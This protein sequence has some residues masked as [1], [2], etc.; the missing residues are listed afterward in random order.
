MRGFAVVGTQVY[1]VDPFAQHL[2]EIDPIDGAVLATLPL[3]VDGVSTSGNGLAMNPDS[4]VVFAVVKNPTSP[5]GGRL[6][7]ILDV[8]TG[9][10]TSIGNTGLKLAGITFGEP[11]TPAPPTMAPALGPLG[12]ATLALALVSA[13]LTGR[14]RVALGRGPAPRDDELRETS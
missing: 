6:L 4:G 5:S 3:T 2:F 11:N 7:A 13:A 14:R 10:A 9:Q 1:G 12:L 8:T